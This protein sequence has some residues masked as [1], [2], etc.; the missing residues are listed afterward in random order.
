MNC[1]SFETRLDDLLDGRCTADRWREAEAHLSGCPR[2]R[3][4]FEAVAGRADDMDA[5]GHESLAQAIVARTCGGGCATVRERLCDFVDGSLAG[6]DRDLFGGHLAHCP[7]CAGLAAALVETS[8]V[9]PSF[10]VLSPRFSLVPDVLAATSRRPVQPTLGERVSAWLAHAA[11]R[12]RFSLE[13]AYVLTVLLLVVLGNPVHAFKEASVRVQPGVSVVRAAVSGPIDR[14]RAAGE[15]KLTIVGQAI[16][17]KARPAG[18]VDVGRV[19]LWQWWQTHVDAPLRSFLLRA[20]VWAT[21][22]VDA[23]RKVMHE[24]NSEPSPPRAR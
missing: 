12:P 15:E 7:A 1:D 9:L 8:S 3:R 20:S 21:G 23:A 17:P 16:A 10:A 18:G 2:C 11:E 4:V 24:S 22:V 13:V 6:L 14:L 19:M 5:A